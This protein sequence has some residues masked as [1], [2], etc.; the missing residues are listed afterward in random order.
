LIRLSQRLVHEMGASHVG[1]G[2]LTTAQVIGKI[3]PL[4]IAE[5]NG[6]SGSADMVLLTDAV[7]Q[8]GPRLAIV[9]ILVV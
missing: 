5:N 1:L 2:S 4:K 7:K 6:C 9:V 8:L 3:V